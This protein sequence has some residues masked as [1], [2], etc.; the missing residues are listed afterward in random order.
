[1]DAFEVDPGLV[2]QFYSYRRHMALKARPNRAH[3]ALAEL[4]KRKPNFHALS[5]NVDGLSQRAGHPPSQLHLLHG[6]LFDL[7][8]SSFFCTYTEQNNFTDPLVPA[9]AIPAE[10][11]THA[12]IDPTSNS[13]RLSSQLEIDVS[14]PSTHLPEVRTR[15]LPHCPSCKTGLLRPGV[16]WFGEMLPK[17]TIAFADDFIGAADRLDLILVIGTSST[18]Y[19]AAGYVE[20]ARAKGARV[21]VINVERTDALREGDWFF[22]GDAGEVVPE[23]LRP[24]VGEVEAGVEE[25]L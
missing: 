9:L 15:D 25:G 22:Q 8:C 6:N 23:L 2:W 24:V 16:V 1:M 21:A 10:P 7:K 20:R 13:A 18:V 12:S 14:D 19:P 5:Q 11:S 4:A 17:E 3:F